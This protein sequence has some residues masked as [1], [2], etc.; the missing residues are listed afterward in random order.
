MLE[1]LKKVEILIRGDITLN[2]VIS[3]YEGKMSLFENVAPIDAIKPYI[4]VINS[5]SSPQ[6]LITD[7]VD[8]PISVFDEGMSGARTLSILDTLE[9][10]LYKAPN[11]EVFRQAKGLVPSSAIDTQHGYISFEIKNRRPDLF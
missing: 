8:Y 6:N 1:V 11:L 7:M 4:V 10:L 5:S 2:A 3:K 9:R